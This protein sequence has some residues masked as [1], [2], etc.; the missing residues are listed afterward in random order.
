MVF[1]GNV[2]SSFAD[3]TLGVQITGFF[4]LFSGSIYAK[5]KKFLNHFKMSRIAVFLGIV[6]LIWMGYSLISH[7]QTGAIFF[8]AIGTLFILHTAIGS[9]AL[10]AGV[11]YAFD[12]LIRKTIIPMRAVFLLWTA[13]LFLGIIFY[14]SNY[15]I[16]WYGT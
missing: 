8:D 15:N 13:A 10:L 1:L 9:L 14:I 4:I 16:I 7:I 12:R 5:R 6:S 2:T 3:M 11:F